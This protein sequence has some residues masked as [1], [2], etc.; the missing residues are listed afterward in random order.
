MQFQS[1]DCLWPIIGSLPTT[2]ARQGEEVTR[3][4][5]RWLPLGSERLPW[6]AVYNEYTTSEFDDGPDGKWLLGRFR[7]ASRS[8]PARSLSPVWHGWPLSR[9]PV[10]FHDSVDLGKNL[11]HP[12]RPRH[13]PLVF[14][15][16]H[17]A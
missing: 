6:L 8:L 12:K 14:A 3:R 1:P 15:H 5:T 2:A 17:A 4:V 13:P 16:P 10:L 7:P 9:C 11:A